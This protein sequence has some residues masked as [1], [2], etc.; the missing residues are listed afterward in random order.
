MLWGGG[1]N[2]PVNL[3]EDWRLVG[4]QLSGGDC[5]SWGWLFDDKFRVFDGCVVPRIDTYLPAKIC[6]SGTG[7]GT[8]SQCKSSSESVT[9]RSSRPGLIK[10]QLN[11]IHALMFIALQWSL[12]QMVPQ[13]IDIVRKEQCKLDMVF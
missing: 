8:D 3:A 4:C 12:W 9:L 10:T 13:H 6:V 7:P 2:T 5:C 1:G 11:V